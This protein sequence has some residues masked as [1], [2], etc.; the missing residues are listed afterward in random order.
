MAIL[1]VF[2]T[3][4]GTMANLEGKRRALIDIPDKERNKPTV[5]GGVGLDADW[6]GL[7]F[8]NVYEEPVRIIFVVPMTL[9][10]VADMPFSFVGDLVTI[11]RVLE[12][13][14]LRGCQ[15]TEK[16]KGGESGP[17]IQD[18]KATQPAT[19]DAP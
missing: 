16:E 11:P 2:A 18:D 19:N 5:F 12:E 9:F 3:G 8:E 4:C 7:T 15:R 13:R 10:C 14:R 17:V 6:I 1:T